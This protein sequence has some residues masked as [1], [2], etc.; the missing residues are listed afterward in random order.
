MM[1]SSTGSKDNLFQGTLVRI[2]ALVEEDAA[3]MVPWSE[4]PVYLR[5][6]DSNAARPQSAALI[7]ADIRKLAGDTGS[8]TYGIRTLAEDRLIGTVGL[9]EIEWSNAV[10]SLSIGIGHRDD[11]GKGYGSDAL[12]LILAYAF[13]ELNLHRLTLTVLAYNERAI[14]LYERSGFQR[15][16]VL[17]EFGQR[18]GR[19]Y[20]MYVYGL[21]RPEWQAHRQGAAPS[22]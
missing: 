6:Q 14:R 7:A 19:R 9:W 3:V 5:L 22:T 13:R 12:R 11:W 15:E 4:D 16:G 10:A 1:A 8:L 2:A 17:R 20:D 18:D 21:L